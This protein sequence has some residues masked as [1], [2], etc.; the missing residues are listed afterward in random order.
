MYFFYVTPLA[1][2]LIIG[3]TLVLG[4]ILGRARDGVEKTL[5]LDRRRGDLRRAGGGQLHL[6]VADPER[7]PDHPGATDRRDLA[8]VLGVTPRRGTARGSSSRTPLA[9]VAHLVAARLTDAH[10]PLGGR[11]SAKPAPA[12]RW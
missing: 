5:H 9:R 1:P 3:I 11:R 8:A 6:A 10:T 7:R 12:A 4:D 2:F